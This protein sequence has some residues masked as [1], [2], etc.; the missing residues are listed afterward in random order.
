MKKEILLSIV[1]PNYNKEN[2]LKRCLDS[3]VKQDLSNVEIIV[4]DD[5]STDNSR[6]ILNEYKN[7]NIILNP[8]NKG[9]CKTRNIGID[10]AKGE[11]ITFLD[12]DDYVTD[13]Y[14]STINEALKTNRE[15][16]VFDVKKYKGDTYRRYYKCSEQG[17]M[18]MGKYINKNPKEYLKAHISY[19][20]WNKIF[21]KNIIKDNQILFEAFDC[22]DED[23]TSRYMLNIEYIYFINKQLYNYCVNET[24]T[25]ERKNIN[26]AEPFRI[27][28]TNNLNMFDKFDGNLDI[29]E[30]EII[31]MFEVGYQLSSSEEDKEKLI[32]NKEELI[33][34]IELKRNKLK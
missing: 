13:D 19:W 27:V 6:D 15:F 2:Y 30:S 12:S 18:S 20:V 32:K 24:S 17:L 4:L 7:I 33:K 26:Y 28:S 16:Y 9:I 34:K 11:Y 21:K 29:I 25:T 1:I 3:L 8:V 23:F 22:E 10:L 5:R 14:I 31:K